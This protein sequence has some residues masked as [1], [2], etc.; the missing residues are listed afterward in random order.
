MPE[1]ATEPADIPPVTTAHVPTTGVVDGHEN[2]AYIARIEAMIAT[3]LPGDL[4]QL[5][6]SLLDSIMSK[7]AIAG[8]F[9]AFCT[10]AFSKPEWAAAASPLIAEMF[11]QDEDVLAEMARIPDLVIE[12]GSGEATVTCM[13]ASRWAARGETHRLSRLAESIVA[14]HASKN[15]CA[16]DVMLA[17]AATLA[18][19]R[20]SRAEQLYNAALPLAGEEHQEAITDARRWLAAGK[21]V[22]GSS[23]EE[24][25]FWDVRLRKPRVGWSWQRNEERQKLKTLVEQLASNLE[26]SE[27]YAAIVP[28]CWWDLAMKYAAQQEKAAELALAHL[29]EPPMPVQP[30]I[31]R[32]PES[33]EKTWS[34]KFELEVPR[35]SRAKREGGLLF[36]GWLCGMMATGLSLFLLPPQLI[37]R[38]LGKVGAADIASSKS[39]AVEVAKGP[40]TP[41]QKAA[42]RLENAQRM[43]TGMA[44][45]ATQHAEALNGSWHGCEKVLSGL[46]EELPHSSSQYIKLLV[47]LHL[48]PPQDKEVRTQVAKLL[49]DRVKSDAIT[50]WEELT[51]P[52]SP[53]VSE[54]KLVA[55]EA[56][57]DASQ[58]WSQD[59]RTRLQ[60]IVD[61]KEKEDLSAKAAK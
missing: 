46:S 59:E 48:D 17:L 60:A 53:N 30:P 5:A 15:T 29:P 41:T 20:Y 11:E 18:V 58:H 44:A 56:L 31:A 4:Q 6:R 14:S 42:W 21:V 45:Y 22:C 33:S 55:Q 35:L 2:E 43:A 61:S 32:T 51:Y 16:V 34:D 54:I 52:G 9:D 47:W 50:L 13:V 10:H 36:L 3:G 23:Q 1:L 12:M 57:N 39:I 49:L 25:D 19:T 40:Q 24:R 28:G 38:L 37:G 27:M 26:G 8:H 7:V